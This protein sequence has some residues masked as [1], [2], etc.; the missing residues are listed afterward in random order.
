M[1]NESTSF[2]QILNIS[3]SNLVIQ[4][5]LSKHQM[6]VKKTNKIDISKD[7]KCEEYEF[8][9]LVSNYSI[10]VTNYF[11]VLDFLNN[12]QLTNRLALK[13]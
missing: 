9:C 12:L 13:L 8:A 3:M 6:T 1:K 11:H 7:N 4:I 2:F 10:I 5:N